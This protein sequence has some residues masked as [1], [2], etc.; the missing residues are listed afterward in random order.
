MADRTVEVKLR[1]VTDQYKREALEAAKATEKVSDHVEELDGDLKKIPRD[2]AAA[3]A[4][5]KLLGTETTSTGQYIKGID[6][7]SNALQ[8]LSTKIKEA[9]ADVRRLGEQFVRTGSVDV[10]ERLNKS[11]SQLRALTAMRK[12]LTDTVGDGVSD[13]FLDGLAASMKSPTLMQAGV[14]IGAVLA[15]PLLA[16]IGG[17]AAAGVGAG[18][19]GLG[20]LG[21]V[22]G[23]PEQFKTAWTATLD[24]LKRQFFNASAPFVGPT[25]DA[26]RSVGPI[27]QSWHIDTIFAN[28]AKFVE[29]L[30]HG[31][32]GFGTGLMKGV[33]DLVKDGGPAIEALSDGMVRLGEAAGNAMSSIASGSEGGATALHDLVTVTSLAIEGFG[34]MIEGAENLYQ[35]LHDHPWMT[36]AY[37][38][39]LSLAIAYVGELDDVSS[40]FGTTEKGLRDAALAAGHAFSEQGEDIKV[41]TQLMNTAI[42]TTDTFAAQ[43]VN[44]IFS[45]TM[46]LDQANLSWHRSLTSLEETLKQNGKAIDK[47]TGLVA[48]NTKAGQDNRQAA[49]A[50]IT[51]NMELYQRQ[52]ASGMSA[53]EAAANY[54]LNTQALERQLRKAG[55]TTAQIEDLIGKYKGIPGEVNSTLAIEGLTKAINDLADLI[56]KINGIDNKNFHSTYTMIYKTQGHPA[57]GEQG[58]IPRVGAYALGG[59]RR[60]QTGLI[61][62]P[63]DPGTVLTGEPQTGGEVLTPLR[64]ITQQ[65]ALDLMQVQGNAHGIDVAPRRWRAS[66]GGSSSPSVVVVQA[67]FTDPVDGT[68]TRRQIVTAA[69][70]RG[71]SVAQFL[72][73]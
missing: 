28:A 35:F 17:V 59:V 46:G 53:Q 62:P 20:I 11:D 41:A 15:V 30:I 47:H 39:G 64:G 68:V 36:A 58:T 27:V 3:A 23:N 16:A 32:G 18:V 63:S 33:G 52:I 72:G 50:S 71:Q 9:E 1:L 34:K 29:P 54:D 49:L 13:G 45:V 6:K 66:G 44:K 19:A 25:M 57:T 69:A 40:R 73:T 70:N 38:G 42:Q 31:L 12:K 37:T 65:H 67:T 5:M 60:A 56:A 2:A 22:L 43:M 24:D 48:L 10:W 21:A 8:V 51:T 14:A 55:Y 7:N 61:I 4:A 26:L